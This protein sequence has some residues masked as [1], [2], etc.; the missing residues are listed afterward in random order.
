M[1]L[2]Q[3]MILL[4]LAL[5][6]AFGGPTYAFEGQKEYENEF[7]FTVLITSSNLGQCSGVASESGLVATAAHCVWDGSGL[8]KN[9]RITFVDVDDLRHT[10]GAKEIFV[11]K[12]YQDQYQAQNSGSSITGFTLHDIAF[13]LPDELV[14]TPR[15]A[16]WITEEIP[17]NVSQ[18]GESTDEFRREIVRLTSELFPTFPYAET[19]VGGFGYHQCSVQYH[20]GPLTKEEEQFLTRDDCAG[21]RLEYGIRSAE[22]LLGTDDLSAPWIWCMSRDSV[23]PGDS[24]GPLFLA[25]R[26]PDSNP[27]NGEWLRGWV[28]VGFISAST[29]RSQCASSILR[30][31]PLYLRARAAAISTVYDHGWKGSPNYLRQQMKYFLGEFFEQLRAPSVAITSALRPFYAPT[32]RSNGKDVPVESFLAEK[33]AFATLWTDRL[34]SLPS[35]PITRRYEKI[36]DDAVTVRCGGSDAMPCRVKATVFWRIAK[37]SDRKFKTGTSEYEFDILPPNRRGRDSPVIL[38]EN[39]RMIG[40]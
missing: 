39:S 16:R 26:V 1:F 19:Y 22:I 29:E 36:R 13:I 17:I 40:R 28:L 30:N 8:A 37:S 20:P 33:K 6:I 11:S 10:V 32:I 35:D 34:Y 18:W 7:S 21:D 25:S 27:T 2:R 4:S 12:D 5:A 23:R 15:H 3:P 9:V 38:S 24:G 31:L 14:Q